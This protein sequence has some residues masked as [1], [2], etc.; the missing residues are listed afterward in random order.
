MKVLK[1]IALRQMPKFVLTIASNKFQ[2]F[3]L[4]MIHRVEHFLE[5][6]VHIQVY[7]GN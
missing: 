4:S 6:P 5:L 3:Q 7:K 2:F 1:D